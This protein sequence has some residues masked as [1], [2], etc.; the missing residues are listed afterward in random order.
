MIHISMCKYAETKCGTGATL[1][2]W[3]IKNNF[4]PNIFQVLCFNCNSK[5]RA[6]II[7]PGDIK[8]TIS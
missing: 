4:P 5:K 2:R 8:I 7:N 1:Y 6:C 3:I